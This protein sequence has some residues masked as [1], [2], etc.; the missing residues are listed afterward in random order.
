MTEGE[1]PLTCCTETDACE[2]METNLERSRLRKSARE[3]DRPMPRF[4]PLV[5]KTTLYGANHIVRVV[6]GAPD[7][8]G[9][10]SYNFVVS[11]ESELE[12]WKVALKAG[13]QFSSQ[14]S[15]WEERLRQLQAKSI[16]ATGRVA[17]FQRALAKAEQ[18]L[19]NLDDECE[20]NQDACAR[21]E[22]LVEWSVMDEV[23]RTARN[24]AQLKAEKL[25]DVLQ[26]DFW[27]GLP[28]GPQR[29][30]SMLLADGQS[31]H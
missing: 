11:D 13:I 27:P 18:A 5:L 21:A 30:A 1:A 4:E 10:P 6:L 8:A 2:Y 19:E 16:E 31:V 22:D 26:N 23:A 14:F 12:K 20:T 29:V 24:Q 7:S 28:P 3:A 9:Y 15:Y 25:T 17:V